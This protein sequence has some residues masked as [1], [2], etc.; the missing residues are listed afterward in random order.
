MSKRYQLG[1]DENGQ[2]K[3][4]EKIL[5]LVWSC[6]DHVIQGNSISFSG[7]VKYDSYSRC[8]FVDPHNWKMRQI[9]YVIRQ[10]LV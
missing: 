1:F 5:L 9:P 10:L 6:M 7:T 8:R 4:V 3:D 2:Y